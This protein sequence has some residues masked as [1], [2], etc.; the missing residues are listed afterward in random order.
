MNGISIKH[1]KKYDDILKK[2]YKLIVLLQN[3]QTVFN[4]QLNQA[5]IREDIRKSFY[6]LYELKIKE[7]NIE[8]N[9]SILNVEKLRVPLFEYEKNLLFPEDP[10][11]IKNI[12]SK[13]K[14]LREKSLEDYTK[15][16]L[17]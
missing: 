2:I 3:D 16:E 13:D 14:G 6:D 15:E 1:L 12:I 4:K 9:V 17:M 11:D 7:E 5:K 10:N 8:Q